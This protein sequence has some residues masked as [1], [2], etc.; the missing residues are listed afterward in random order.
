MI[1][2][3]KNIG[4][5]YSLNVATLIVLITVDAVTGWRVWSIGYLAPFVIIASS[6]AMTIILFIKR[7]KCVNICCFSLSLQ[8]MD[9]FGCSLLVQP[10]GVYYGPALRELCT[11][12]F[13]LSAMMIFFDKQLRTN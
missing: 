13:L 10:Y 12:C 5:N 6:C 3:R 7:N 8:S 9:L 1:L 2:S 11:R 4:W